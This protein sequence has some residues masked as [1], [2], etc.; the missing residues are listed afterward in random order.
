M[1]KDVYQ[2]ILL[3][4]IHTLCDSYLKKYRLYLITTQEK[5]LLLSHPPNPLSY[6]YLKKNVEHPDLPP[7]YPDPNH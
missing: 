7:E 2:Q 1:Y 3:D 5:V 4:V 6:H